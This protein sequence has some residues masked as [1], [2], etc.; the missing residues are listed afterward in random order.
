MDVMIEE[1]KGLPTTCISDAMSGLNNMDPAIKPV[2]EN[3]TV[4]GRAHTVK[5]RAGDN[6]MVL[7]AISEASPGD[8]LVVDAKGYLYNA[9]AGDFV[10]ALA[11]TMGIAGIIIDGVVRD[12]VG[13]QR[14]DF[15]VF[16]KGTTVAASDKAGTGE[17][18]VNISCG[19]T[20]VKPRDIIVGD[21]DGVVVV[22]REEETEVLRKSKLKLVKDQ[23]REQNVLVSKEAAV[24]YLQNVLKQE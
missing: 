22:P 18:G 1:F 11:K 24:R 16:C 3:L 5:L 2:K 20:V 23:D 21:T 19:G 17:V 9:S 13:I 12:L 10:V 4:A 14:L 8:I 15:P 7:K 6:Y